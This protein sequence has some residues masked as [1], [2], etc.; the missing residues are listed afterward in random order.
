MV[1]IIKLSIFK[2]ISPTPYGDQ[3][4]MFHFHHALKMS[5]IQNDCGMMGGNFTST[6]THEDMAREKYKL[7]IS[8]NNAINKC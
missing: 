3:L 8:K 4:K 7:V 5:I 6:W 2:I 1:E